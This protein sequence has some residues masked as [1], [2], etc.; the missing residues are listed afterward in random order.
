MRLIWKKYDSAFDPIVTLL[1]LG[2]FLGGGYGFVLL[3]PSVVRYPVV[4]VLAAVPLLFASIGVITLV[5]EY[6]LWKQ[7]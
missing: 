2:F 1:G 3:T 7:R 5:R 4:G 6:G